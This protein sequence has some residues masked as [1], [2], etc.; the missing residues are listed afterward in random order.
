MS[1]LFHDALGSLS[2]WLGV[3]VVVC[4]IFGIFI[5]WRDRRR[6]KKHGARRQHTY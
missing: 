2:A 4:V 3:A 5:D 1:A 6:A